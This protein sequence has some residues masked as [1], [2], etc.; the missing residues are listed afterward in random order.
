MFHRVASFIYADAPHETRSRRY[1]PTATML[2]KLRKAALHDDADPHNL[3]GYL[4]GNPP[5]QAGSQRQGRQ[6]APPTCASKR[7]AMTLARGA[8]VD[9][10]RDS[11][12]S[13]YK[14]AFVH[15]RLNSKYLR[16]EIDK[17]YLL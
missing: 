14:I 11:I 3:H 10:T 6:L 12:L 7:Q 5:R 16:S 15:L 17:T 8:Y 4:T 2:T 9:I 1:I 13:I